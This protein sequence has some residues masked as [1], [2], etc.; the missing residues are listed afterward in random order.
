MLMKNNFLVITSCSLIIFLTSFHTNPQTKALSIGVHEE[1][2]KH[3]NKFLNGRDPIDIIDF[4]GPLSYRDIIEQILLLQALKLGGFSDE[5]EL[6]NVDFYGRRV[7]LIEKGF[8]DMSATPLWYSDL[9]YSKE[10]IYI[11][12]PILKS[13]EFNVGLYVHHEMRELLEAKSLSDVQK[14]VAISNRDWKPFWQTLKELNLKAIIHS[15]QFISMTKM[16]VKKRGDFMLSPFYNTQDLSFVE[17]GE[18]FIPIPN[19][20]IS[21]SGTRHFVVSKHHPKAKQVIA[22]INNGLEILKNKGTIKKAY[23]QSG[24]FNEKVKNWQII[25]LHDDN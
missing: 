3:V 8:L 21:M 25:N 14:M 4:G 7:K 6:I 9:L 19:M 22:A 17:G 18:K 20:K 11:S 16:L 10:E 23:T 1:G 12:E 5:I 2:Q 24:F 15:G 13:G